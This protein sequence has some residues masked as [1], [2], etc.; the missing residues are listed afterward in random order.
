MAA[1]NATA[2]GLIA[3]MIVLLITFG[4]ALAMGIVS[5]ASIVISTARAIDRAEPHVTPPAAKPVGQHA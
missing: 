4:S 1:S 5:A 2:V 3:A